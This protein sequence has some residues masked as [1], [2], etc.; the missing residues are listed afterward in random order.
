[1]I[2]GNF[3]SPEVRELEVVPDFSNPL[4]LATAKKLPPFVYDRDE[5]NDL[6]LMKRPPVELENGA[7]YDGFFNRSG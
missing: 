4:T 1:V 6:G 3:G 2:P 5:E 7:V